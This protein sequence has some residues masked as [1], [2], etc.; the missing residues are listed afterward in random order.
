VDSVIDGIK[1]DPQ[2]VIERYSRAPQ[3]AR[4]IE[5]QESAAGFDEAAVYG[6]IDV[7]ALDDGGYF[8]DS[9]SM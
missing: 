6:G 1:K 8:A 4:T 9:P 5:H 3:K 7:S 2:G